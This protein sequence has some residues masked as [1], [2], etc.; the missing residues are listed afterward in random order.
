M[1]L[2]DLFK[3]KEGS[4]GEEGVSWSLRRR[5]KKA[6]SKYS[7]AEERQ[8]AL[9][10]LA[11]DGSQPAIEALIKRFGF[12]VEP[13]TT[14]EREREYVYDTLMGFGGSIIP[15]L[16][17]N[18]RE[19]NSI[20]WQL[21]LYHELASEKDVL[22]TLIEI[23]EGYDTEYE[24]NPQRKIQIIEALGEWQSER[25]AAVL[26]RFLEDVDEEVRYQTVLS[27]LNQDPGTTRDRLMEIA[28]QDESNRIRDFIIDGFIDREVSIKGY[29]SRKQF[30]ELLGNEK[31][32]DKQG[33]IKRRP[34]RKR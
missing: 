16:V 8:G 19:S 33:L 1:G 27:L 15:L 4:K 6:H 9:Q 29:P 11:E 18:I 21:R 22:D 5:I 28:M 12:Y 14:D 2:F 13:L 23:I 25:V 7:P 31:F 30:E 34:Q 17:K 10:G 20:Q 3:K 32:V 24:K 26:M